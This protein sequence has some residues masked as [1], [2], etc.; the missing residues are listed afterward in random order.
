MNNNRG[1]ELEVL[2]PADTPY[3]GTFYTLPLI[4]YTQLHGVTS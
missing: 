4:S 1:E 3:R 2:G